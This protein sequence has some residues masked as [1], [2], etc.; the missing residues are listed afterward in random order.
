MRERTSS[1]TASGIANPAAWG[2]HFITRMPFFKIV[3]RYDRRIRQRLK[4]QIGAKIRQAALRLVGVPMRQFIGSRGDVSAPDDALRL[5]AKHHQQKRVA[6]I[7][8]A[9]VPTTPIQI[10]G[11]IVI[12]AADGIRLVY[13]SPPF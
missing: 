13:P 12:D 9:T 7:D 8:V 10:V 4:Q 3:E 5:N 11:L 2:V 1:A 6:N